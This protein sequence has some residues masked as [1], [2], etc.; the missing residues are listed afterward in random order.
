MSPTSVTKIYCP[1]TGFYLMMR[2]S[3]LN[4]SLPGLMEFDVFF[5]RIGPEGSIL[6]NVLFSLAKAA[7]KI[8]FPQLKLFRVASSRY[9]TVANKDV[10][11]T[12]KTVSIQ[13]KNGRIDCKSSWVHA[14][15]IISITRKPPNWIISIILFHNISSSTTVLAY[16]QNIVTNLFESRNLK[17]SKVQ[18]GPND[19]VYII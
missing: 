8:I 1:K 19:V 11:I 14:I 13:T 17:A 18:I 10:L 12:S 15:K 6:Q 4:S 7:K 5:S 3:S 2:F 9:T 16:E